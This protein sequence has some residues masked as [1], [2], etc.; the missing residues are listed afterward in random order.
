MTVLI[1]AAALAGIGGISW[2]VYWWS[3]EPDAEKYCL[4]CRKVTRW[5]G[6]QGCRECRW[7]DQQL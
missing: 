5:H 4:V 7:A 6:T 1:W 3:G 2:L